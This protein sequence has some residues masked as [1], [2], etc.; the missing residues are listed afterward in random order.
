M[1]DNN[2]ILSPL[3]PLCN[4]ISTFIT[5]LVGSF[6]SF[7]GNADHI[8]FRWLLSGEV[9]VLQSLIGYT[10]L[11]K[12]CFKLFVMPFF[13]W[14]IFFVCAFYQPR[15]DYF[16]V[17]KMWDN[18]SEVIKKIYREKCIF[19]LWKFSFRII[20]SELPSLLCHSVTCAGKWS[21]LF[22]ASFQ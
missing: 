19:S 12:N 7:N 17:W 2:H 4:N 1:E 10:I 21:Y 20:S 15:D 3:K 11:Y 22:L 16:S 18:S 5:S 13:F 14:S 6:H 8:A 9:T